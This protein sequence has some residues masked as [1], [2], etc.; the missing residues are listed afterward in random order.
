[1]INVIDHNPAVD[2]VAEAERLKEI[3]LKRLKDAYPDVSID[4]LIIMAERG[5]SKGTAMRIVAD[6]R[7][8]KNRAEIHDASKV[9]KT[10]A[11]ASASA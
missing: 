4:A 9:P 10:K 1:M 6:R 7:R 11:A 8:A 3:S 5:Y 2:E